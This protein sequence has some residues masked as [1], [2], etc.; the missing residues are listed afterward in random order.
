MAIVALAIG[1]ALVAAL[2]LKAPSPPGITRPV[3]AEQLPVARSA[4]E[5]L[6][7]LP[8]PDT[9]SPSGK[10]MAAATAQVRKAPENAVGWVTLGDLLAQRQRDSADPKF[11]DFAE[12]AY[13]HALLL[14]PR[15]SGAMSGMAWVTGGRHV[16]DESTRWAEKAIEVDPGNA[17]AVGI[18]GDAEVELGDYDQAFEHYQ[19]MM[20]LRPDLSSWSRGAHLLWLTGDKTNAIW[21]MERAIKAGAPF[22]ENTAWCRAKLAMKAGNSSV[23]RS[24]KALP[25][26]SSSIR[27]RVKASRRSSGSFYSPASITSSSGRITSC[28][29]SDCCCWEAAWGSF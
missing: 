23:R 28:L 17:A 27:V 1:A 29:S 4:D 18:L 26:R 20:D 11:Y 5:I 6:A 22:A 19:T 12:M 24:W 13:G 14:Q 16:F 9:T 21:L 2:V 3:V 8:E 10:V 7:L 15:S 25:R